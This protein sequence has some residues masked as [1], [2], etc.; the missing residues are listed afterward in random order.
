MI[1]T[2]GEVIPVGYPIYDTTYATARVVNSKGDQTQSHPIREA[3]IMA[4]G[5]DPYTDIPFTLIEVFE[6][7]TP[8]I[9]GRRVVPT[10]IVPSSN[11]HIYDEYD[12]EEGTY[13]C[14]MKIDEN[15]E[16]RH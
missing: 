2:T 5:H 9:T 13:S 4:Y 6:D 11:I 12:C 3:A 7:H 15:L 1:L 16:K 14:V 8:H 10:G